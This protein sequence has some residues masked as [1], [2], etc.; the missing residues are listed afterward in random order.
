MIY[1]IIGS[2]IVAYVATLQQVRFQYPQ[3]YIIYDAITGGFCSVLTT[4]GNFIVDT[5]ILLAMHNGFYKATVNWLMTLVLSF[6]AYQIGRILAIFWKKGSLYTVDLQVMDN[7]EKRIH[8]ELLR[9]EAQTK[10]EQESIFNKQTNYG[11]TLD[12]VERKRLNSLEQF[13]ARQMEK[14]RRHV[15]TR[16]KPRHI[17]L[18]LTIIF[19]V[20]GNIVTVCVLQ[21]AF[22]NQLDDS[23]PRSFIGFDFSIC[24][25][26]SVLGALSGRYIRLLG[27]PDR[28]GHVQWGTFRVNVI[29]CIIIGTAHNILLLRRYIFGDDVYMVIVLQRLVGNFCGA[30]SNWGGFIDETTTLWFQKGCKIVAIRNFFYNLILCAIIFLVVV[31]SVR[32]SFFYDVRLFL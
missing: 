9:Q 4:F 11:T 25:A 2:S 31:L 3:T 30:E 13:V 5:D 6:A 8:F 24:L 21:F 22:Y 7:E 32:L 1:N 27:K 18:A 14:K 26:W 10:Q 23:D 28:R 15:T 20:V 19:I 12:D 17:L 16:L 29:S